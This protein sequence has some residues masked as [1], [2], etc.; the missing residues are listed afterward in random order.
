M[1]KGSH[2]TLGLPV[3]YPSYRNE[4]HFCRTQQL[5][6][7]AKRSKFI[8]N[9]CLGDCNWT[10]LWN[11]LSGVV[12]KIVLPR[13]LEGVQCWSAWCG[14]PRV[15]QH[16]KFLDFLHLWCKKQC[17]TGS[18]RLTSVYLLIHTMM[19]SSYLTFAARVVVSE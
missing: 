13:W 15:L 18:R 9:F 12:V 3:V 17:V 19:S 4:K 2:V 11:L 14:Q 6:V 5:P 16:R 8:S 1:R 10:I 7:F